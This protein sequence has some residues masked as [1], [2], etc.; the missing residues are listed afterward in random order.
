MSVVIKGM[1]LP[2][3]CSACPLVKTF[4]AE[5]Y[6]PITQKIVTENGVFG[7]ERHHFCLMGEY[8]PY[9][10]KPENTPK[11]NYNHYQKPKKTKSKNPDGTFG[12]ARLTPYKTG[13]KRSGFV[14]PYF[15]EDN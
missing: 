13:V 6:C 4:G 8:S 10:I 15:R 3:S 2:R 11:K 14:E 1:N 7:K 5:A 9:E 12:M